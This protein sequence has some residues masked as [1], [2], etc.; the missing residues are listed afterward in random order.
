MAYVSSRASLD[1]LT[2]SLANKL[3]PRGIR[4]NTVAGG[5][6]SDVMNDEEVFGYSKNITPLGRLGASKEI[7]NVV[8]FLCSEKSS[9][10]NGAVINVDGGYS[11]FDFISKLEFE[12][13]KDF[14][15]DYSSLDAVPDGV[16]RIKYYSGPDAYLKMNQDMLDAKG[17]VYSL[18]P[19]GGELIDY[20]TQVQ[21]DKLTQAMH[22][23]GIKVREM[24]NATKADAWT[25][26]SEYIKSGNHIRRNLPIQ[27]HD[28][29]AKHVMVYD[30]KLVTYY[31][32]GSDFK[33][34]LLE[35]K[36][37]AGM[38][39]GLCESLWKQSIEMVATDEFGGCEV[40]DSQ[41]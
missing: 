19:T 17:V 1:S 4:V 40:V 22:E 25:T 36:L 11:N 34:V 23:R 8:S 21:H 12:Q 38:F 9:F 13:S 14:N 2:K 18:E 16:S 32:D 5:W 41:Y 29:G 10:V 33:S 20:M 3:G 27:L 39:R 35:D 28:I 24:T 30:D 15:R 26:V 31:K 37:V 6:I 7:A